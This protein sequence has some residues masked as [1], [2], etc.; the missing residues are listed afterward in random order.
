MSPI[1]RVYWHCIPFSL[2]LQSHI[3]LNMKRFVILIFLAL[4]P[5]VGFS[6]SSHD[7]KFNTN[8][9]MGDVLF[10]ENE[11]G[12]VVISEVVLASFRADT[13]KALAMQFMDEMD[14]TDEVNI[15]KIDEGLTKISASVEVKEGTRYVAIPYGPAIKKARSVVDFTMV[16]DFRD[17]KYRFT[18]SNF[19][20]DR[21]RIRGDG[22]DQGPSN[23][24]HWQRVNS[25]KK[26]FIWKSTREEMIAEEEDAYAEEYK[27]VMAFVDK[28][29]AFAVISD[30]F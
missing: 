10:P 26:D 15:S 8:G 2:Y 16:I 9:P 1:I 11:E 17:G 3:L 22:K 14:R 28:L 13:L 27:A 30:D 18:L 7:A 21:W 12:D 4:L 24:I 19:N 6:Q 29:K 20:T 23:R 5:I 25:I